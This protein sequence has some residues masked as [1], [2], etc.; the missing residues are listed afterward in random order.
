MKKLRQQAQRN[1]GIQY[2]R[3]ASPSSEASDYIPPKIASEK[4]SS[5]GQAV[6]GI[7]HLSAID[8]N[9]PSNDMSYTQTTVFAQHPRAV[10][11]MPQQPHTRRLAA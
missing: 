11:E 7:H 4:R 2:D 1:I 6:K 5:Q 9:M 8:S 10:H 3:T